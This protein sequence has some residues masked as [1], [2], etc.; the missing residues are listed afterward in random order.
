MI[1]PELKKNPYTGKPMQRSLQQFPE[2]GQINIQILKEWLARDMPDYTI[3]INSREKFDEMVK[4][5]DE[6]DINKVILFTKKEKVT[7]PFKGVAA[8]LRDKIRFYIVHVPEK[9]PRKDLVALAEAYNATELPKLILEQT[10]DNEFDKIVETTQSA[11]GSKSYKYR[12]LH[13]FMSKYA[14]QTA[15]EESEEMVQQ[16]E[17]Q[18]TKEATDQIRDLI[19]LDVDN[20]DKEIVQMNDA[21]MVY[22]TT[23]GAEEEI[24]KE[25]KYF[26]QLAR[27]LMGPIKVAV[28]RMSPEAAN[29]K[30]LKKEFRVGKLDA[31][32]PELRYYPNEA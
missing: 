1:P 28:F 22:F 24:T 16:K 14:R 30:D 18:S 8:E 4:S 23:L 2:G 13:Q 9:N 32:K 29:F 3:K 17:D 7:L 11:Y 21:C 27:K 6:L 5:E 26:K 19:E 31:G 15:K 20:F 10:Y 12:D 25:Y